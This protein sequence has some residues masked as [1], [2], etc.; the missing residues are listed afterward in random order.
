MQFAR[1]LFSRAALD[2]TGQVTEGIADSGHKKFGVQS[3]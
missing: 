3:G 1:S 2:P